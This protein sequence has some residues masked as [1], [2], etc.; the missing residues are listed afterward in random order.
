M[1]VVRSF[2]LE[3]ARIDPAFG[4]TDGYVRTAVDCPIAERKV[5]EMPVAESDGVALTFS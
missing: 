4:P 5:V 3:S 2:E 1:A